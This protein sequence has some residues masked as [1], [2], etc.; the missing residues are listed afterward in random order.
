M[1]RA[2]VDTCDTVLAV[3][4]QVFLPDYPPRVADRDSRVLQLCKLHR[5]ANQ[6]P[7][8]KPEPRLTL[9]V[10]YSKPLRLVPAACTHHTTGIPAWCLS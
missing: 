9:L 1:L 4:A 10:L 8:V 3:A 6:P 2:C 7:V 5:V